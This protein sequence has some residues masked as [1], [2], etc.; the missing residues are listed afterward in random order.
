MPLELDNTG[1]AAPVAPSRVE[2]ENTLGLPARPEPSSHR[3]RQA[4][5]AWRWRRSAGGDANM[6][7]LTLGQS[8]HRQGSA[9]RVVQDLPASV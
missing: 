8:L 4:S 2:I 7:L 1:K 9:D 6:P 3:S 5:R